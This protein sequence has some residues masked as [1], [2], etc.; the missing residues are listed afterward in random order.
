M[1]IAV[2]V[3]HICSTPVLI[4][5]YWVDGSIF[6][7][8]QL[9]YL[10]STSV[11]FTLFKV[12]WHIC[13]PEAKLTAGSYTSYVCDWATI[14]FSFLTDLS[15]QIASDIGLPAHM[16]RWSKIMHCIGV[17]YQDSDSFK[18]NR[19]EQSSPRGVHCSL[20]A[21]VRCEKILIV[22]WTCKKYPK[23]SMMQSC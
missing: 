23:F 11:V 13:K 12:A 22:F 3:R 5:S 6:L 16:I 14:T 1:K 7:Y 15:D 8:V 4:V 9:T 18:T 17:W 21:L 10:T 19:Q 20:H 2:P